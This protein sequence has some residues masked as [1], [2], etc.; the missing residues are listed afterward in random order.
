M[1][2]EEKIPQQVR[3]SVAI[4][5]T[6]VVGGLAFGAGLFTGAHSQAAGASIALIGEKPPSDVD[7]SPVWKAWRIIDEKFVP[8]SVSTTS[9]AAASTTDPNL[10]RVWG[11]VQGL[12]GS[13]DDPYSYFLPPAEQKQ[14]QESAEK[15]GALYAVVRSIDDIQALGL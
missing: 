15:A 7:L 8:A 5:M 13:L 14:F 6:L 10:K 9:I 12:A 11:M 1:F 2:D 4:A 3:F